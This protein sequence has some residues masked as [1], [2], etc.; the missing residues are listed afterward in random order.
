MRLK[1]I[2]FW[3]FAEFLLVYAIC[4]LVFFVFWI[5]PSLSGLTG[6]HIAADSSTYMYM[7]DVLRNHTYDPAVYIA[8]TT[9]PNT[10]WMPVLIA[11]AL[12]STTLIILLNVGI[13]VVSMLLMRKSAA[14][15]T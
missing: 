6:Q 12:N 14:I 1:T 8:L 5:N 3:M 11:Y 2:L 4:C 15:D 13:F 10:L 9:I 7:A